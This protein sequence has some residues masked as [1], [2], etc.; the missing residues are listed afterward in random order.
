M[1][2][3][4]PFLSQFFEAADRPGGLTRPPP[5]CDDVHMSSQRITFSPED[6]IS[7]PEAAKELQVNDMTVYRWIEKGKVKHPVRIAK[8]VF[9]TVDEVRALKSSKTS[10]QK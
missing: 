8:Q 4:P 1:N 5:L 10:N 7:V 6:L 2:L 3:R 9:L